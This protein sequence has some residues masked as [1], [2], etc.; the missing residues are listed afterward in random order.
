MNKYCIKTRKNLSNICMYYMNVDMSK[1]RRNRF[2][3]YLF[4]NSSM[5]R[6]NNV[7]MNRTARDNDFFFHFIAL[8]II[9][10][11]QSLWVCIYHHNYKYKSTDNGLL[12]KW[13][14]LQKNLKLYTYSCP[15]DE[16]AMVSQRNWNS[17]TKTNKIIVNNKAQLSKRVAVWWKSDYGF[18]LF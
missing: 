17:M 1:Y 3:M 12:N 9:L 16:F 4:R 8:H 15:A 2:Y 14:N 5:K 13:Q 18:V 6:K 11:K 7:N 10:A